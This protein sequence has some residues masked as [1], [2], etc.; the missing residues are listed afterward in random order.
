VQLSP[1]TLRQVSYFKDLSAADLEWLTGAVSLHRYRGRE[2]LI[3][4]GEPCDGFY[5]LLGGRARIYKTSRSGRQQVLAILQPG[6]T[7]NEVPVFD[8]GPN[9]AGVETLEPS[10]II[11]I[12]REAALALIGRSPHAAQTLLASLAARLR[13]FALLVESLAFDDV[14]RRLARFI[15]QLARTG[16]RHEPE[17]IVVARSL[18]V[19][20]IAAMIG[21]VREVVTRGLAQ[22]EREGLLQVSRSELVV[23]DL[24]GLERFGEE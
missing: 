6:D 1:P 20:D 7:F 8:G 18:T 22:F 14:N 3:R 15:A 16:G 17:G 5:A 9:P 2:V 4:E 21:T 11:T 12:P 23:L 19:Q 10:S 13:G 24:A